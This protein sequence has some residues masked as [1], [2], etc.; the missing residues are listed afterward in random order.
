M[1]NPEILANAPHY[2]E[3]FVGARP[4]SHVV[5][6]NFFTE[7]AMAALYREFPA[8]EKKHAL[9]EFG[10]VGGK[11][12]VTDLKQVSPSYER[13]Y[14]Y[15]N[16]PAF[17]DAMSAI[18]GIPDLLPDPQLY[19]GG[20]HENVEGQELDPH[21]DYNYI[22]GGSLHRRLN[23]L[24][25]FNKEWEE[26]WGGAIELHSNPRRPEEDEITGF[27]PLYNRAL[28]FETNEYS[29][30]GFRK[31]QLPDG[32]KHLTRKS[33]AI[34]L[35]TKTRPEQEVAPPHSTFYV[36]RPLPDY[37]KPGHTLTPDS[38]REIQILMR[39]RDDWIEFY[40][41]KELQDSR[42]IQQLSGQVEALRRSLGYTPPA[43]DS[44][45]QPRPRISASYLAHRLYHGLPVS[46]ERKMKFKSFIF[47]HFGPLFRN[48][49]AYK[50]WKNFKP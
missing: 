18:T 47:T 19:G 32:K 1:I 8:F 38:L 14:E 24:L 5:M 3:S 31:I 42:T 43:P 45:D 29:W 20:T 23:L 41:K 13:L 46:M 40:Q 11:A 2:R 26:S 4:F 35:Y 39:R 37:I 9:N 44:P 7:E 49:Q 30:H 21:V 27:L 48:R 34:Y 50:N 25:Y 16:S 36:Q 33:L 15:L 6:E 17:L 12:V 28:V 10:E 22:S